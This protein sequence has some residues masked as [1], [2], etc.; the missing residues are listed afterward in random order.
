MD[1]FFEEEFK[2]KV[3]DSNI[4]VIMDFYADWCGPCRAMS[5]VIENVAK[6]YE[7]K[8]SLVKVDCDEC[9][10]LAADMEIKSIPTV[11]AMNNGEQVAKNVGYMNETQV[12]K[13]IELVIKQFHFWVRLAVFEKSGRNTPLLVT[14]N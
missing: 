10:D 4:P 3:L 5:P 11:I 13:F 9:E 2:E 14:A 12:K 7:G 8:V 1:H 6:E